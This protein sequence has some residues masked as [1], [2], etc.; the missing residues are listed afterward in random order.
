MSQGKIGLVPYNSSDKL[1]TI[2]R[3][4]GQ[5]FLSFY[6]V[7]ISLSFTQTN[8]SHVIFTINGYGICHLSFS[9]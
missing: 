5:A 3:K 2:Y 4:A 8:F 1:Q 9:I 6:P 7:E